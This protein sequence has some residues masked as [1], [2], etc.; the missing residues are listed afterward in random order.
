MAPGKTG[1]KKVAVIGY[2]SQGRAL[3]LN[4]RD[5]GYDV[6]IGLRSGS[7]SRRSAKKDGWRQ[8]GTIRQ[9]VAGADIICFAFPDHLHGRVYDR[10]IR[11]YVRPGSTLWFLQ[12][13]SVHFGFVKPPADCDVILI[14]PHA[15]GSAV[16]EK[17]ASKRSFSAFYAVYRDYSGRAQKTVKSLA[18]A[19][20]VSRKGLVPTSFEAEAIGD[21]FGEQAVLCGGMA[22]LIKNGFDVLVENG[23]P[24][25]NAY[26][27]VA[28]QLDLI[29]DLVKQHGI[30]GMLK[31]ISVAARYGSVQAGPEIINNSVKKRMQQIYRRIESGRFSRQLNRLKYQDIARLNR[32]LKALSSPALEK[33]ARKFKPES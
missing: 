5:S 28:Y 8:N 20:G 11:K 17:F 23:L 29:V 6:I 10:E 21:L 24:A 1:G 2:G 30:E 19:V 16:R 12:G 7:G 25:E 31:R 9:A 18:Q 22:A 32:E 4:L 3:A 14:A 13:M 26:L 27:E 33:A 15:P